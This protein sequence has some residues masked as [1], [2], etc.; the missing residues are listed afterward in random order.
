MHVCVLGAT[1]FIGGQIA[2]AAVEAGWRVRAVRRDPTRTGAIGELSVEWV[3]ADLCDGDALAAAMRGCALVFHAAAAY[4]QGRRISQAVAAARA[5]MQRVLDAAR[6]AD[7]QRLI[8]TS[9]L[10]TLARRAVSGAATLPATEQ[11]YYAPG[12]ANSAYYEAK[13]AMEQMALHARDI[14]VVTL[15]PTAVMG[16][17]DLKPTTSI[18]IREVARGRVPFYFD[19]VVNIVDGRDVAR[20]HLAAATKG[21]PG[22]RYN[23]GGHNLALRDALAII[24]RIAGRR[25][26][27]IRLS[28]AWLAWLVK[29]TDA[30]PVV[31]LPDHLRMFEWW[32]PVSSAKAEREL[33]H[34]ARPFE[35]TVRDTLRWFGFVPR[36]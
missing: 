14:E 23:L 26:P 5:E 33:G 29:L 3:Q 18:V 12:T 9:S 20:S 8:Y 25:P 32:G 36:A 7:V 19:A 35:E 13:F 15:L 30:L 11:D 16:P 24:A 17:G 6:A 2:R 34:V 22:E 4:P 21:R 1:G 28:R 27:R 10:T 31:H